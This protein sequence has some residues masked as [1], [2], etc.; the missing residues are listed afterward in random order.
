VPVAKQPQLFM[1]LAGLV[2]VGVVM[3][4]L[5]VVLGVSAAAAVSSIDAAASMDANLMRTM[6]AVMGGLVVVGT[7]C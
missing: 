1:A 2:T 3:W 5:M 4:F 7:R 6:V